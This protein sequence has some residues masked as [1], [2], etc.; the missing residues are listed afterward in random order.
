MARVSR[1]PGS[2]SVAKIV[3]QRACCGCG[4]CAAVCPNASIH[5]VYGARFNFPSVDEEACRSCGKCLKVCP[6]EFLMRGTDSGFEEPPFD[7]SHE[8][9]VVHSTDNQ[10][11]LDGA[12]GGFVTGIVW[13]MIRT[14]SVDGGVV[15]RCQGE[16]AL[17][18]RSFTAR[19][20]DGLLSAQGSKY[21]PVSSCT[22]IREILETPGRYVFVGTPCMIQAATQMERVLPN[23]KER[24]VLKIGFVCAGMASR[25]STRAYIEKDGG[26]S[27]R[28]VRRIVY[29]GSG[30]PGRFRVFGEGNRLLMDR[31]LIGGSLEH[32]V[33]RDHYL[34]CWNCLDHWSHFADIVVS[35]PWNQEMVENETVGWSAVMV[36]TERGRNAVASAINAGDLISKRITLA[37]M[38]RYNSHLLLGPQHERVSWMAWYQVLFFRRLAYLLPLFRGLLRGKARGFRTTWKA[39]MEARYYY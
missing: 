7:S 37:E 22:S 11:R 5:F 32:L 19:D 13:H 16:D 26:V 31:P 17:I 6:S 12:S 15:A 27:L 24:I 20:R 3:R 25:L 39:R 2:Q 36:R 14:G 38:L 9:Y 23:L 18:A 35:D 28:D 4:A 34:R 29:R 1:N 30:W 8:C 33:G 21:A 10:I